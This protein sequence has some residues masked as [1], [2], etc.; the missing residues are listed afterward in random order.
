[1]A[2]SD[3]S[4]SLWH[5]RQLL[6]LLLFKLEVE[7]CLLTAGTSRWLP[8]ATREIEAVI[9]AVRQAELARAVEVQRACSELG[10]GEAATL[11]EL[12]RAAPRPWEGILEEHRR[13]LLHAT[14]E[15]VAL[16]ES[17]RA[18]LARGHR[19]AREALAGVGAARAGTSA[20]AGVRL[21]GVAGLLDEDR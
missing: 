14:Q 13:A 4:N 10:L 20:P 15:L 3:V 11:R 19:A 16:A 7:R 1:M 12:A 21:A 5:E 9:D 18:L 2:L 6:D 17:N 8:H